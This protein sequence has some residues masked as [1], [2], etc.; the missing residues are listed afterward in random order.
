[1]PSH[2]SCV[3]VGGG[4]AGLTSG[5]YTA[6]EG[7]STLIVE[8]AGIGGQAGITRRQREKSGGC[9]KRTA[10]GRR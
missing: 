5:I 10:S 2:P 7:M 3:I 8:R 1:M 6:R 4:P 9:L